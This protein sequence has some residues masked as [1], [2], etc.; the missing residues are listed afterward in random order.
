MLRMKKFLS[1][2]VL[3]LIGIIV[4][5]CGEA[6][7]KA[8]ISFNKETVNLTVGDTYEIKPEI[9]NASNDFDINFS[10]DL[11][12]LN[13]NVITC[14]KKGEVTVTISLKSDSSISASIK[15]VIAGSGKPVI[16]YNGSVNEVDANGVVDLKADVTATD[17]EDGDLTASI[18]V[19]GS[20][21]TSKAGN[22]EI[23]YSV[24]DSD[25]NKGEL[26]RTIKVLEP[27]TTS[28][29]I[30]KNNSDE[31]VS[32]SYGRDYD[33]KTDLKALDDRDGDITDK[34]TITKD[35]NKY[36][37]D[38][39]QTVEVEVQDK[40][41]N[42]AT[43]TRKVKVIWNYQTKFIGH[44][45]SIYGVPNTYEAFETAARDMHYHALECDLRVT[46]DGVLVINHDATYAGMTVENT[47]YV[48]LKATT[49]TSNPF[50]LPKEKGL[51][52]GP[53]TGTICTLEEY[54]GI[55]KKYGC[56][57]VVELKSTTGI[58]GS[59][60]SNLKKLV[61]TLKSCEMY[62]N[63]IIL[64]SMTNC[65]KWFRENGYNDIKI[66]KLV[67]SIES[68]DQLT[69]CIQY[70]FDISCN[71]TGGHSNSDEWLNRYREAG[72]EI[73]VWTF[74]SYSD[75]DILQEWIDKGVNY[76]TVDWQEMDKL[77]YYTPE[78]LRC[79]KFY[80]KAGEVIR[81]RYLFDGMS[82]E[83]P[84]V[85]NENGYRFV[86]WDKDFT[87]ISSDLEIKPVY[88][89]I[90]YDIKYVPN[91][92]KIEAVDWTDKNE[93][94]NEFYGD[95]F[96][97]LNDKVGK[98]PGL[99]KSGD[100]LTKYSND[101]Y[102]GTVSFSSAEEL[103][104]MNTYTF[105]SAMSSCFYKPITDGNNGP[106]YVP[107]EDELYFLNCEPYRT[108]YFRLNEYFYNAM[109]TS[110]TKYNKNYEPD[111]NM[112]VSLFIKLQQ[113]AQGTSIAVLNN[114]PAKLVVTK[115]TGVTVTMP[116]EHLTYTVEDKFDLPI[117][118]ATGAKFDG[119][120]IKLDCTG[121]KVTSIE[122]GTFGNI[123]LY[124]KWIKE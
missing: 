60:T 69:Q 124:A 101:T 80:N 123:T 44:R 116:T 55:C 23:K 30:S 66:Q 58:S 37:L 70:D 108:K 57:A 10:G 92:Y 114:I 102:N 12:S 13:G 82:A 36:L 91:A 99:T 121:E 72:R 76:V 42:K 59:S 21:D 97:W 53:Y 89:K 109:L 117:P 18:V 67:N 93:F 38:E 52:V 46:S 27:D 115:L 34:I 1:F 65:L 50:A 43:L 4:V 112:K 61:D 17:E 107:E 54:L 24:T 84:D 64:S 51:A 62:D 35:I 104:Q 96:A 111:E 74:T 98:V 68:A 81:T 120:Y 90:V 113:W 79:V 73:S 14:V 85:P 26:V 28:P 45:G 105:E 49:L 56:I 110:F 95:F 22:Y 8:T 11:I 25:G 16:V 3:L 20:V 88:E 94:I 15:L 39:E 41:G 29:V 83:A 9:K 33:P 106:N 86:K 63:T 87:Y 103:K 19:E 122:E 118:T 75:Y 40:A 48:K 71:V 78:E 100:K 31:V 2:I 7:K 77:H 47:T 6:N 119:W 32:I 5:G